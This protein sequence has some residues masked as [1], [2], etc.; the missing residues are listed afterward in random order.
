MQ[1][2]EKTCDTENFLF[3]TVYGLGNISSKIIIKK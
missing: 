1:Y 3:V 2:H